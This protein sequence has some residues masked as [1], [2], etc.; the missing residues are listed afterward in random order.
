MDYANSLK[1]TTG[2]LVQSKEGSFR[3]N[4]W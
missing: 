4:G 1:N 3:K 2:V